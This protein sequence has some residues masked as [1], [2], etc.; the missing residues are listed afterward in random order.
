MSETIRRHFLWPEPQPLAPRHFFSSCP[1][2]E[3]ERLLAELY[4]AAHPVLFSSARAGLA[5][6]LQAIGVGR[7]DFIWVPPFSS[8]C[9]IDVV[10]RFGTPTVI[11]VDIPKAAL[12][13]H[14]W[15][16]RQT[17]AF[18]VSCTVIEDAV[19]TLFKPGNCVFRCGGRFVL[20]SLPKTIGSVFGGVVFCADLSDARLLRDSLDRVAVPCAHAWLKV[21]GKRFPWAGHYWN[22]V[23]PRAGRLPGFAVAQIWELLN[24]IDG[25][26]AGRED[27]FR[28]FQAA[29]GVAWE[30]DTAWPSNLPL[31]GTADDPLWSAAGPFTAGYRSFNVSGA[32]PQTDMRRVAPLP[33]HRDIEFS[34]LER[35]AGKIAQ[36]QLQPLPASALP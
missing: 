22:D 8:H 14:Q 16:H 5:G 2:D 30:D 27:F 7:P 29:A 15:G 25:V 23:E 13:Y 24:R 19:D 21:L 26:C 3:V 35:V 31:V 18:P 10:G 9:V 11:P 36:R 28:R 20:W 17:A 12:V 6:V 32:M 1:A 4:P 33:V 34:A